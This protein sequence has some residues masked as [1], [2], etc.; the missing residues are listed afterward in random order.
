MKRFVITLMLLIGLVGS[1]FAK[2]RLREY[3]TDPSIIEWECEDGSIIKVGDFYYCTYK[4]G[5]TIVYHIENPEKRSVIEARAV[6]S[7]EDLAVQNLVKWIEEDGENLINLP[8]SIY[9]FYELDERGYAT[10]CTTYERAGNELVQTEY[11]AFTK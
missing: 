6:T 7:K 3:F 10:T 1:A 4:Y 2:P 11:K 5:N 8:C 9:Y